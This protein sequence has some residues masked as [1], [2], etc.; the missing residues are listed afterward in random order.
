MFKRDKKHCEKRK[1]ADY[2]HFRFPHHFLEA[3]FFT[4]I[5][6]RKNFMLS[7][8]SSFLFWVITWCNLAANDYHMAFYCACWKQNMDFHLP[9]IKL[10]MAATQWNKCE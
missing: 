5:K 1:N 7:V 8:N 2:Q 10:K 4:V 3:F 6:S 9:F